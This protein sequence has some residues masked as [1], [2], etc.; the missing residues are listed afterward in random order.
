MLKNPNNPRW[1]HRRR[2][3]YACVFSLLL[4]F[5][6]CVPL[7]IF[8]PLASENLAQVS[9]ILGT[10]AIAIAGIVGSYNGF[11]THEDVKRGEKPSLE[12]IERGP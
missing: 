6:G 5:V 3:A 8:Y 10:M 12:E 1:K 4:V 7:A 9:G 2:I 11:A